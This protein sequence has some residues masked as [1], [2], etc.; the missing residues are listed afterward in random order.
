M[1]ARRAVAL[2]SN[3]SETRTALAVTLGGDREF[4]AAEREFRRALELNPSDAHAHYWYSV[5]LVA[6]GRADEAL[7]EAN[8]AEQLDPFAPRGVTAMQRY[9]RYL[10][11]EGRPHRKLPAAERANPV[12][13]L[14]PGEPFAV[15]SVAVALAEEGRCNE[16]RAELGRA[17]QLAPG[18]NSRMQGMAG[19]VHL[20]CGD[21]ARALAI[22]EEM[23]RRPDAHDHGH[24][25]AMLLAQLGERDS[26]LVWLGR[27]RWTLGQFSGLSADYRLDPVRSDP[28]Y[29]RLLRD[30][31]LRKT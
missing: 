25:I 20:A 8:R 5:L 30:L 16:A 12:L 28:R 2:D 21:R 22:V 15:V 13:K 11:G 10:K 19:A 9:A 17:Q 4:E 3:L 31:G 1:M 29:Q 24:R 6:L 7:R 18:N 23:K 14:E 26:A 27:N